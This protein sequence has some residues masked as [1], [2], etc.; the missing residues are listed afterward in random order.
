[1]PVKRTAKN[2]FN[3]VKDT[4]ESED[5]LHVFQ[6]DTLRS[7][8]PDREY[9][10]LVRREE[11]QDDTLKHEHVYHEIVLIES[12]TAEHITEL[13][14]Q[15]LHPGDIIIIKPRMWH[16]Y[17][18]TKDLQIINCLFDRRILND[19][20]KLVS[21][22]SGAFE[23]FLRP[24]PNQRV[25]PPLLLHANPAQR[26]RMLENLETIIAEMDQKEQ[27]WRAVVTLRL[28]DFLIAILRLKRGGFQTAGK[29]LSNH[30]LEAVD[31]AVVY[32]E[33]NYREEISLAQVASHFHICPS[34]LSRV[35]STRVGMGIVQYLHHLRVEEACRRLRSCDTAIS[36][37]A[38][39][40]GYNEIAYFSRRFR[41]ETGTSAM[42]YR[43][44]YRGRQ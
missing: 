25:S 36:Q 5:A 23:L 15:K 40:V 22:V 13:G 21:M 28:I 39:D 10:I 37:I 12:G 3:R 35:F 29:P 33:S 31:Q 19:H 41:R 1:M 16:A 14:S 43:K 6:F 38:T 34:Y 18:K 9:L 26:A 30:A 24:S 11:A 20:A 27:D 2:D 42:E 32:L 17:R 8:L 44:K 4:F 7:P